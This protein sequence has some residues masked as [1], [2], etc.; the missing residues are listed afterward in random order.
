VNPN[1]NKVSSETLAKQFGERGISVDTLDR[2]ARQDPKLA[3][4]RWR[5]GW[6]DVRKLRAAGYLQEQEVTHV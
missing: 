4:C 6:W 1:A 2:W 5:K 3:A